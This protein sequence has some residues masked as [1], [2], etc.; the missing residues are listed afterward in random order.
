MTDD[1]IVRLLRDTTPPLPDGLVDAT[2]RVDLWPRLVTR[3]G[4]PFTPHWFDV[5]LAIV[6]VALL[7][8]FPGWLWL[9]AY[10]L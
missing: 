5:G 7:F 8:A 10:Q 4:R 2:A 6:V 1:D 9:L 3:V